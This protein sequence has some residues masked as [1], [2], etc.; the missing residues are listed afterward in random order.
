MVCVC[1]VLQK[2]EPVPEESGKADLI[3]NLSQQL[4]QS[5]QH[6]K[7]QVTLQGWKTD[8]TIIYLWFY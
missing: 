7:E 3:E 2:S 4:Q 5:R 8:V 1:V 6:I